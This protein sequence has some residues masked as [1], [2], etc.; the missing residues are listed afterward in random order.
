MAARKIWVLGERICRNDFIKK[1]MLFK[2]LIQSVMSYGVEVW[3]WEE[4]EVLEKVMMDYVRWIFR[5]EFCTPRYIIMRE[6]RMD[7]L[8][9]GWGI[10]ALRYEE[11]VKGEG[12][13]SILKKCWREKERKGWKE[14]YSREREKYYNRNGWGVEAL[15][16]LKNRGL[17]IT[18]EIV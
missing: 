7:K 15:E 10:R 2:Y 14:T 16:D 1:W 6:L 4:K 17:I 9:V 8:K 3:G 11:R 18:Y 12:E 13:E 5:L